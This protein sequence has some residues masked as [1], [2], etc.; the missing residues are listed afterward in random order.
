MM[1]QQM[2]VRYT[3]TVENNDMIYTLKWNLS[4]LNAFVLNS[5]SI[6]K[7]SRIVT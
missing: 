1:V 7:L 2:T 4:I 5:S 3:E 6:L